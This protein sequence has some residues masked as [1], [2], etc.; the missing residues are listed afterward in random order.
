M[1]RAANAETY[2]RAAQKLLR[3]Y[4]EVSA[5]QV[6]HEVHGCGELARL[7]DRDADRAMEESGL[8]ERTQLVN[9]KPTGVMIWRLANGCD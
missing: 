5:K 1:K 6:A 4:I 9:G 3:E 7:H 2:V 8:F